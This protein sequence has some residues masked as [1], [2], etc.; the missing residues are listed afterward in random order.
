M[1]KSQST[2][3]IEKPAVSDRK[4]EA[5]RKNALKSTGPRT[6]KGKSHSRRNA[7]R[8]GLYMDHTKIELCQEQQEEFDELCFQIWCDLQPVGILEE[9]AVQRIAMFE[10]KSIRLW[11]YENAMVGIATRNVV[12]R[13]DEEE[14]R[15]SELFRKNSFGVP[16]R[17]TD[18]ENH[19]GNGASQGLSPSMTETAFSKP[20]SLQVPEEKSPAVLFAENYRDMLD[21]NITA[22]EVDSEAVPHPIILDKIHRAQR[23]I[24][25]GRN[26][27]FKQL[28]KTR[29]WRQKINIKDFQMNFDD[30]VVT[31]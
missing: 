13:Q 15:K 19:S 24:E 21:W 31:V 25:K 22:A 3:P 1:E 9:L 27:A 26:D 10:W 11:R 12:N 29:K 18:E 2:T 8:H 14:A 16:Q 4:L 23:A 7:I 17:V 5:N 28:N 30:E 20:D 6:A